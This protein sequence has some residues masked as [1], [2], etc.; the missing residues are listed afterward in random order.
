MV[1]SP[2]DSVIITS[3][4]ATTGLPRGTHIL[5]IRTRTSTGFWSLYEGQEF[6]IKEAIVQAEYFLIRIPEWAMGFLFLLEPF[7]TL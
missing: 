1:S 5:F 6:Y 7:Q 3:T 2:A 4:I